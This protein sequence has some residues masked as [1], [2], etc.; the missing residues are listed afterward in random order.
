MDCAI[1]FTLCSALFKPAPPPQYD[2]LRS[3]ILSAKGLAKLANIAQITIPEIINEHINRTQ[4]LITLLN[5]AKK[6]GRKSMLNIGTALIQNSYL[7]NKDNIPKQFS[8]A[9]HFAQ[10]N[11]PFVILD[12]EPTDET[13]TNALKLLKMT[14]KQI[15]IKDLYAL[16]ILADPLKVFIYLFIYLFI[17]YLFYFVFK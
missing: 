10:F 4:I 17:Y 2:P 8:N 11:I 16:I 7:I 12:G 15:S 3:H 6:I 13:R 5:L 1:M 9:K 14:D